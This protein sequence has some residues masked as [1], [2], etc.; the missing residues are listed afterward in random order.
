VFCYV[1]R[2]MFSEGSEKSWD[3]CKIKLKNLKSQWR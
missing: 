3:Q 1:S 2:K